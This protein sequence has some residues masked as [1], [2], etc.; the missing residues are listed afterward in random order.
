MAEVVKHFFPRLV[1]LHNYQPTS[2]KK[3]KI[4]NW[5]ALNRKRARC[6]ACRLTAGH[7]F[8]I[9][10]LLALAFYRQS[11]PEDEVQNR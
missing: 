11:I 1:E 2:S 5:Q 6:R 3:N 4:Y 9:C 10:A 7:W 8:L